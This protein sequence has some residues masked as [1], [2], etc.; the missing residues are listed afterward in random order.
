MITPQRMAEFVSLVQDV[1]H[2]QRVYRHTLSPFLKRH[3]PM[4]E[5]QLD[6]ETAELMADP[7]VARLLAEQQRVNEEAATV[8]PEG[9]VS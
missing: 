4:L 7:D 3:L 6:R 9:G 1:R 5:E 2:T 8:A